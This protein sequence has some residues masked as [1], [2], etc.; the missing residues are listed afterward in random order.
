MILYTDGNIK[1]YI[2]TK[3]RNV[4][5]L[6]GGRNSFRCRQRDESDNHES[7]KFISY[8]KMLKEMKRTNSRIYGPYTFNSQCK[9]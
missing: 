7:F 5:V 8:K 6:E 1:S 9:L 2:V 3:N 4:I